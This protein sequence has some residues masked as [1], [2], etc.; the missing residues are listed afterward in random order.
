MIEKEDRLRDQLSCRRQLKF[1]N[2]EVRSNS[3]TAIENT[4]ARGLYPRSGRWCWRRCRRRGNLTFSRRLRHSFLIGRIAP[5]IV[6]VKG[7]T[8]IV[9][10]NKPSVRR[11]VVGS[12]QCQSRAA[13]QRVN[14][15]YQPFPKTRLSN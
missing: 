9:A 10:L 3:A 14:A 12:C 13:E 6:F 5:N 1:L 7:T 8:R 2:L 11:K 15:L 4:T